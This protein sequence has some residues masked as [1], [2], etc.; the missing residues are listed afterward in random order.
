MRTC[1]IVIREHRTEVRKPN[2]P[3]RPHKSSGAFYRI[4]PLRTDSGDSGEAV[5][6][7]L[8]GFDGQGNALIAEKK[9][10]V[11]SVPVSHLTEA[12]GLDDPQTGT[13]WKVRYFVIDDDQTA[14]ALLAHLRSAGY[15]VWPY[16]AERPHRP[17]PADDA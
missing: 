8:L 12:R 16:L 15:T 2:S 17:A 11:R 3:R 6:G 4:E 10:Q 13:N 1:P 14:A 9:G 5:E 7:R